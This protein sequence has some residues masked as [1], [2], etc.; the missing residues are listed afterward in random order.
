MAQRLIDAVL[1]S[2]FYLH[3]FWDALKASIIVLVDYIKGLSII[4]QCGHCRRLVF[5]QQV[6]VIEYFYLFINFFNYE[7]KINKTK[8]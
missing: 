1:I 6:S 7:E 8:L 5:I 2:L 4:E 3:T